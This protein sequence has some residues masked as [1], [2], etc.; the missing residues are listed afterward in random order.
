MYVDGS[1]IASNT[2]YDTDSGVLGGSQMTLSG[3]PTYAWSG[4]IDDLAVW[5]R[6]LPRDAIESLWNEGDGRV[7][8]IPPPP[9][10][11]MLLLIR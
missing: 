7:A 8:Y 9:P 1:V 6:A 5:D 10:G 4:K 11:G 2:A 3:A